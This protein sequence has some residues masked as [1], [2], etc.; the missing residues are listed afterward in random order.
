VNRGLSQKKLA[1]DAGI[2]RS[3]VGGLEREKENPTVDL[4]DRLA[5]ALSSRPEERPRR[6]RCAADVDRPSDCYPDERWL[7]RSAAGSFDA[8]VRGLIE[9][10]IIDVRCKGPKQTWF[11]IGRKPPESKPAAAGPPG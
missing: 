4:L 2:D 5:K 10:G 1:F 3:Y 6:S 11:L 9:R 7:E 8:P